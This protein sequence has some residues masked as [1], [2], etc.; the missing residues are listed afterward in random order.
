[1]IDKDKKTSL[2]IDKGLFY[3]LARFNYSETLGN[4]METNV[5]TCRP[6]ERVKDVAKEMASRRISSVIVTDESL[7]PIGIVTERD[8][9]KKIVVLLDKDITRKKISEIMTPDPVYLSPEDTLFDALSVLTR[10]S[11]KH[12][13]IVR[14]SKVVGIITLRQIIKIRYSE[15]LII[16][17]ELQKAESPEE[18]RKIREDMLF[19]VREKLE[20]NTDP[21]DIV[22]MISL[23]NT[24]IHRRLL[25]R[26]LKEVGRE[27]PVDFC[28]FVTGSHG[29]KENLL[30]PDQDFCVIIDDYD[31]KYFNE[32]DRFF[33]EL[34]LSFS[35]MLSEAGFAYCPGNVMGQNP[36]WR[37]RISEWISH[38]SYMF[39]RPGLYTVRYMTL[40]FDSAHLYGNKKLFQRYI[41]YAFKE[42]SQNYNILRQMHEEEKRHRVPLGW[43]NTFI[44]EKDP[45]H[46]G[47][48]DMK[49]S[50]LIFI[51]EAARILAMKYEVKETSTLK[52]L[53]ALVKKG[54][55]H[56]DD[57][58][59]FENA[60]RVILYHTLK[61]QVENYFTRSTHDYYLKPGDLS[62]RNQEILKQAFK[63]VSRLQEIVGSEFGELIL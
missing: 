9:V 6:D 46:K 2:L 30:F 22:N 20:A 13:P 18:F 26:A 52:R 1:M 63:A 44:T 60:Y 56:K 49:R 50:A 16:I 29:R 40:V 11:I 62:A 42:L 55:I 32:F 25:N 54:V 21:V 48:I 7:S 39:Q 45:D 15:P 38:L 53:Q 14:N 8:M 28:F 61:A 12:L 4:I 23:V 31:D 37:K 3:R 47:E 10:Y 35:K 43:F 57:S 5:Y 58:E 51:I 27:M 34:A 17:G 19:L 33:Y 36:I 59:Y 41:D 24:S